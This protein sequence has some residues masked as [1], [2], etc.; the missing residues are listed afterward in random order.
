MS[1]PLPVESEGRVISRP[2]TTLDY[3]RDRA[4]RGLCYGFAWLTV[5]VVVL[6]VW[7]IGRK[8]LPTLRSQGTDFLTT[9]K[10]D[11]GKGKF[12]IAAEI[13]GT[14]YSSLLAVAIAT[15]LGVNVAI[16]LTQDQ[17][18]VFLVLKHESKLRNIIR[19]SVV[20]G[21]IVHMRLVQDEQ[22]VHTLLRHKPSQPSGALAV[23][24]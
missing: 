16:L 12:G 11:P 6:I 19:E 22:R 14:L 7:E 13:G 24:L 4:F 15:V 8:A 3:Y 2:P 17:P 23:F 9:S 18:R 21:E 1:S 20:A 10:W 5:L